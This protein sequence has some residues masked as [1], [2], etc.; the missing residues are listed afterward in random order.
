MPCLPS[1]Y[2][3]LCPCVRPWL[4]QR[5]DDVGMAPVLVGHWEGAWVAAADI[6]SG[7]YFGSSEKSE[8]EG[9]IIDHQEVLDSFSISR[10][11]LDSDQ[12]L[13]L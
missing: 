4:S 1:A 8:D 12:Q 5:T 6:F 11:A 2:S 7:Y 9:H 10:K 3:I 13:Q